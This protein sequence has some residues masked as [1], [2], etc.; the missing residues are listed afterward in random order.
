MLRI[1]ESKLRLDGFACSRGAVATQE[2]DLTPYQGQIVRV[3]LDNNLKMVVNPHYDC[4]WQLAEMVLNPPQ[5]QQMEKGI[6]EIEERE[7]L[8]IHRSD[9]DEDTLDDPGGTVE[10]IGFEW[11]NYRR[12]S[13]WDAACASNKLTITWLTERRPK[14]GEEYPVTIRKTREVPDVASVEVPLDLT[15]INI[16]TYEL[17]V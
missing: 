8:Y 3:Y 9:T 5:T 14:E 6:K 1:F 2:V 13:E 4:F 17:P 12:G 7:T 15:K 16:V 10:L 11:Q